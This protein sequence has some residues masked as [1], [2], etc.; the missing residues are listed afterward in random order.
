MDTHPPGA[1]L[2]RFGEIELETRSGEL[3]RHGLRIRL[4][5]QSFQILKL[6]LSRPGEVVSREELQR[7]LWTA[8][9][10]VDFE[11]GLNSAVRKLREALDD[12]ADSPRF[13][14][15][16]PRHGYRFI[17]PLTA[18]TPEPIAGPEMLQEQPALAAPPAR[19]LAEQPPV[20]VSMPLA[21]HPR[22]VRV[23]P[24]RAAAHV[25]G[26][27]TSTQTSINLHFQRFW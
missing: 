19:D 2:K 23:I 12:A 1:Q 21:I 20:P 6:L 16:V 5:E 25:E 14:T 7:A 17:G 15:R 8:D 3:R 24:W 4:P 18:L 11:V 9:T 22:R 26:Y 13:V 10:F 27:A